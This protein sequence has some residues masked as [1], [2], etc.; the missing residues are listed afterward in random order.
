MYLSLPTAKISNP[1]VTRLINS[2]EIQSVVRPAGPKSQPRPWTQKKNPLRNKQV[3]LSAHFRFPPTVFSPAFSRTTCIL[4]HAVY[5]RAESIHAHYLTLRHAWCIRSAQARTTAP[6]RRPRTVSR[7]L[8]MVDQRTVRRYPKQS[9]PAIGTTRSLF[10]GVYAVNNVC[11]VYIQTTL[12]VYSSETSV[13]C[14]FSA[15]Q[16]SLF[17]L[18]VN[19]HEVL[20][21]TRCP[22][23]RG[24]SRRCV[25][26]RLRR[27]QCTSI[28][29]IILIIHSQTDYRSCSLSTCRRFTHDD[30]C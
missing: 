24:F 12:A 22:C 30:R 2:T 21:R 11:R 3:R 19:S 27:W 28:T 20:Y 26:S 18:F 14:T 8:V 15:I 29:T 7:S 23:R 13:F 17:D 16:D 9:R 4:D 6:T 25:H 1:D 5:Q 10:R